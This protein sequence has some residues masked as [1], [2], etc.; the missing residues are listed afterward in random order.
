[1]PGKHRKP[2]LKLLLQLAEGCC[3]DDS[4]S[5]LDSD[6]HPFPTVLSVFLQG[7]RKL[8]EAEPLLREALEAT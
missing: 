8:A 3:G 7:L 1:M 6:Y 5:A 4:S 2:L